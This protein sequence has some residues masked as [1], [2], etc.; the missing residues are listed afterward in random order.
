M[1]I[2]S[3]PGS[4]VTRHGRI[5]QYVAQGFSNT[6]SVSADFGAVAL[7]TGFMLIDLSDAVNW[8]HT[9][10]DHI[11]LEYC[12]LA[13]NGDSSFRGTVEMGYLKNVDA[14][15]GDFVE[16]FGVDFTSKSETVIEE[17]DFTSHGLHCTDTFHFGLPTVNSTI[18]QTDVD[19]EGP[20][21]AS[22]YPSGA[23]DVVLLVTRTGGIV[24]VQVT[25][26][27]ETV[28]A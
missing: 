23:G 4:T 16:I 28:G 7:T 22:S 27:Y 11:I 25:L 12:A 19:L 15:N 2:T 8:P 26:G 10:T 14:T 18:F 24:D 17:L 9:E 20:D 3:V 1:P 6:F 21:G 5:S 13:I